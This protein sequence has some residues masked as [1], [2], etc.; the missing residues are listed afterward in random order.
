L[1][2]ADLQDIAW[3]RYDPE[4]GKPTKQLLNG[5]NVLAGDA[6]DNVLLQDNDVIVVNRNLITRV[7]FVLNTF[8]QPFRDIL[9]FLLFFQQLQSGVENLFS[10]S[11]S[12]SGSSNSN[13]KK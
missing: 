13:K 11:G 8:T 12:S 4:T 9:G 2:L 10:P 5:K 3:I 1:N 6:T 7:S